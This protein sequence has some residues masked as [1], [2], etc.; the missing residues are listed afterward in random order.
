[1]LD[2][3]LVGLGEPGL[4]LVLSVGNRGSLCDLFPFN[5]VVLTIIRAWDT[6]VSEETE[7]ER[8]RQNELLEFALLC[9]LEESVHWASW[10]FQFE[11]NLD[12]LYSSLAK[13]SL[14]T[15]KN[16]C[17]SFCQ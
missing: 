2:F 6:H 10:S 8:C 5:M 11:Q 12:F 16:V 17:L 3:D 13:R 14:I 7:T 1:L 4:V 15:V 9:A